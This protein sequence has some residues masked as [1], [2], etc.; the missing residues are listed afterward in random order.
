MEAS[1]YMFKGP[2]GREIAIFFIVLTVTLVVISVP[3]IWGRISRL[4]DIEKAFFMRGR[5]LGLSREEIQLLWNYARRFPYDPQMIY[6]NKSLFE[7]VVSR[8]VRED[9]A[10]VRLI[11]SIRAKLRFDTVPWFIPL[12]NTRDID[13]YQTG[14]LVV[15]GIYIDAA[16]WDKTETELHIVVL[17]ALPRPVRIGESVKFHFVRENEGRYSFESV[18]RDKYTEGDRLVLVL[19]H[20]ET[21]HRVQLRESLRWKVN[22]PVEF[23]VLED[24]SEKAV[25]TAV[26]VGGRIDDISTKGVRICTDALLKPREG[27]YIIMSFS[28][29]DYRFDNMVGQIVNVRSTQT[30]VCMGV[31]FLKVSRQEEKIID[32]FILEEQRKLIKTYKIGETD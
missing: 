26:F 25:K 10:G 23:A 18:V 5:S 17:E 2:T 3:Y 20:T 11:P 29:K 8:I 24:L 21:M 7:K 27:Q 12:T 14:K 1:R 6:D 9:F 31:K 19:E 28:I 16:V 4:K 22:I 15:D 30:Q 13:L 32:R